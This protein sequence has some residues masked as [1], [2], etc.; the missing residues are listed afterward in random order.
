MIPVGLFGAEQNMHGMESVDGFKT[1]T[2]GWPD[3]LYSTRSQDGR[4][5]S[6]TPGV[7]RDLG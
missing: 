1:R 2:A 3:R 6:T 5:G 4:I 7:K